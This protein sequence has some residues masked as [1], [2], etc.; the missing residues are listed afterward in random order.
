[1]TDE[2]LRI[3]DYRL[4]ITDWGV[5]LFERY[6][7]FFFARTCIDESCAYICTRL[8]KR[9]PVRLGVRTSDF[10][11]GNRGSIPLRAT[12][13]THQHT[14]LKSVRCVSFLGVV[15]MVVGLCRLASEL[16]G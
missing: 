4:Q 14:D 7:L 6:A 3:T 1:M 12:T 13:V 2:R 8:E 11:S 9:W 5:L 16:H 10:H 15:G